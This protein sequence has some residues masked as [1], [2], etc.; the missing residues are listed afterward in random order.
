MN[1]TDFWNDSA[2]CGAIV[3]GASMVFAWMGDATGSGIFSVTWM[4]IHIYLLYRFTR[5]RATRLAV[6]NHDYGFG[7]RWLFL[8]TTSLLAGIFNGAYLLLAMNTLFS[9]RYNA[10]LQQSL[11]LME[12][13]NL[14][15]TEILDEIP[16][17]IHAPT[18]IVGASILSEVLYAC[19]V[20]LVIA[21][22]AQ[23]R[24]LNSNNDDE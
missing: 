5:Q 17:A 18:I 23:P 15:S 1:Q 9:E 24:I 13:S 2:R 3:G 19:T 20:G 8:L 16:G 21:A 11:Q 12:E 7:P 22:I 4:V 14:Y 10:A 6:A